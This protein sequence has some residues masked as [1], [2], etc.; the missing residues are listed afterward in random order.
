MNL[1]LLKPFVSRRD[2]LHLSSLLVEA[3]S[4]LWLQTFSFLCVSSTTVAEKREGEK[5]AACG[6]FRQ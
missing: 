1:A 5:E 6:V 3:H 2:P 4:H